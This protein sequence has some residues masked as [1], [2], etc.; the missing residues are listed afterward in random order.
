MVI[1]GLWWLIQALMIFAVFVD[2]TDMW[3]KLIIGVLGRGRVPRADQP[4]EAA[5]V[6]QG[7][8]G[9]VRDNRDRGRRDRH[10]RLFR[11]GVGAFVFGAVSVLIGLLV[12]LNAQFSTE[13]LITLF[14]VLL[15][16]DGVA[17]LPGHQE[18][19]VH[20]QWPLLPAP[21]ASIPRCPIS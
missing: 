21:E 17:D 8:I 11:G 2:R 6:F 18:R 10:H 12:L 9:V 4:G 3:W 7:V 1:L 15:L 14:A 19:C 16:I 13:L 20:L 5:D